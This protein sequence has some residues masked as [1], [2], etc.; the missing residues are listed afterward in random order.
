MNNLSSCCFIVFPA[1]VLLNLVIVLN[2]NI[3]CPHRSNIAI[4]VPTNNE[5]SSCVGKKM[6]NPK[7]Y[8]LCGGKQI[9]RK[10]IA[11]RTTS[12]G[13]STAPLMQG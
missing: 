8:R 4:V 5:D 13:G 10:H 2:V 11:I 1:V 7:G 12:F 6:P 3:L 9:C